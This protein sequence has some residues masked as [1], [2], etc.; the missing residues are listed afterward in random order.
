MPVLSVHTNITIEDNDGLLKKASS[1]VSEALGK[2]EGYVMIMLS[3]RE[4]MSFAGSTG[5]LAYVELKSLGLTSDQTTSLSET[6][7]AFIEQNLSIDPSRIY[8]EFAS[9]ERAMFG[10]NRSTF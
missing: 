6:I 5:P 3:D 8:I 2:P 7:C 4:V 9:P 1:I 10:W